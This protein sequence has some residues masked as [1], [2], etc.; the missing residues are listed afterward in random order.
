[1][2]SEGGPQPGERADQPGRRAE[3]AGC[4]GGGSPGVATPAQVVVE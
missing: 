4:A 1:M 2:P 3:P